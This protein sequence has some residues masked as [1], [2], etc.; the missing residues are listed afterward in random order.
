[1]EKATLSFFYFFYGSIN[2]DGYEEK[3]DHALPGRL[4]YHW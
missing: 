2:S 4:I 1:M 3:N